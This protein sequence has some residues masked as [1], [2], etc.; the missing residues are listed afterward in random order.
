MVCTVCSKHICL[1]NTMTL[2]HNHIVGGGVFFVL[3]QS[4][5]CFCQNRFVNIERAICDV[6]H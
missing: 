5:G 1:I 6:V 4:L 3:G 2:H